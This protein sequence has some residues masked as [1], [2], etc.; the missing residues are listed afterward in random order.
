MTV[1]E[2]ESAFQWLRYSNVP[3]TPIVVLALFLTYAT[4]F[5]MALPWPSSWL[6]RKPWNCITCATGWVAILYA[7]VQPLYLDEP[8]PPITIVAAAG[9]ALMLVTIRRWLVAHTSTWTPP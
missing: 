2:P 7:L 6:Q 8:V 5:L 3:M 9:L 1:V 4:E